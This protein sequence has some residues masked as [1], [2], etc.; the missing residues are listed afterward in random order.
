[1]PPA[2]YMDQNKMVGAVGCVKYIQETTAALHIIKLC[3][4]F[5]CYDCLETHLRKRILNLDYTTCF[6]FLGKNTMHFK[7][8]TV[9]NRLSNCERSEFPPYTCLASLFQLEEEKYQ[10]CKI[11]NT[12][13][14]FEFT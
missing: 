13:L 5:T 11:E 4:V 2:T 12:I 14:K 6:Y 7:I 3:N 1:M 10:M 9:F 8:Q